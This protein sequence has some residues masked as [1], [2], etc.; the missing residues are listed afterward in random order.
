MVQPIRPQDASGVYRQQAAATAGTR[1][2]QGASDAGNAGNAGSVNGAGRR[3][4]RV[5][6]S[7]QAQEM[8]RAL[9]AVAAQPDVRAERVAEL[10]QQ[11]ADGT[12][13]VD[14]RAIASRMVRE[15]HIA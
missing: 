10:R 6:L 7:P 1:G 11:V 5:Q 14:A 4:D 3:T 15:G 2:A 8:Q 12:Y 13:E 9:D